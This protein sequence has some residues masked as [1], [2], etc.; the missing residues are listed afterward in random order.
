MEK[1]L[2]SQEGHAARSPCRH[3]LCASGTV[4]NGG[5]GGEGE[6]GAGACSVCLLV[7]HLNSDYA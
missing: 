6:N 4:A 1:N 7:E 3:V 5:E 2:D